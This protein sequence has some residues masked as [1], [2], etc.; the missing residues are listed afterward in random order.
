MLVGPLM[1]RNLVVPRVRERKRL[2]SP[3]YAESQGL[4]SP[5][6]FVPRS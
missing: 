6:L 5:G 1:D 3:G 4:R 2:M